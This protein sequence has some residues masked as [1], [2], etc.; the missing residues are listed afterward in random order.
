MWIAIL[1]ALALVVLGVLVLRDPSSEF[2]CM[3]VA[4]LFFLLVSAVMLLATIS[5]VFLRQG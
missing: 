4:V 2:D 3:S 1:V 5:T